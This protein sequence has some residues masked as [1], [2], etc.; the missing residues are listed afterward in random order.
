MVA[1]DNAFMLE[2][3]MYTL[4]KTHFRQ[5]KAYVTATLARTWL[6]CTR[7]RPRCAC[8]NYMRKAILCSADTGLLPVGWSVDFWVVR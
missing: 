7:T 6:A 8:M 1:I 2:N 3:T 5:H 4:L